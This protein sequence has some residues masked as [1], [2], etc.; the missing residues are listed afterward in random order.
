LYNIKINNF[1]GPFDLLFHLIEKNQMDIY[2]I[3]INEITDQYMD[4]LYSMKELDLEISS[5][6][7]LMAS[8]LLHIKSRMLLP[9]K[10]DQVEDNEDPR[11]DL[12]LKLVEYKKFKEISAIFD[13]KQKEHYKT[14]YKY[15]EPISFI[16]D[17]EILTL[18]PET[19]KKAWM[20]IYNINRNKMV[21]NTVKMQRIIQQEKVSIA[22]KIK[23]VLDELKKRTK[24]IFSEIFQIG[25]HTKLE[26]ITGFQAILEL[27]KG[28]KVIINQSKNF[29]NI[30]VR[31]R[32][33]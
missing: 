23:D 16:Y 15:P 22:E 17:D 31:S 9:Y 32:E 27:S 13:K 14:L 6:F 33:K 10:K 19:L 30:N 4:F 18:D 2:D 12:V 26:V 3:K 29:G 20:N 1:E 8:T 28:K 25:K 7:L 24:F 5:A 21:D 11:L